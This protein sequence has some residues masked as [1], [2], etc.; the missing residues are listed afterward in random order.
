MT[1]NKSNFEKINKFILENKEK[2][3]KNPEII[4]ISKNHT[5]ESIN[6]AIKHGIR[7]FGEN[8]LQEA[9]IKFKPIKKKFKDIELHL[10]GPLQTKK[11]IKALE[12]FDVFHT[13][14]REKLANKIQANINNFSNKKFFIQVNIGKEEQKSGID[15]K[16]TPSFISYCQ[17]DLKLPI[18]GL[19]CI[20]PIDENAEDYFLKLKK[21][22]NENGLKYLSMGMSADY[23]TALLNGATHVRLGTTLFGS[24][25]KI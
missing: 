25:K 12:L 2:I 9:E 22:A 21:I 19:M 13:L 5:S 7:K 3:V 11:T 24:R 6:E 15:P 8:R 18:I 4:A 17:V 20:P 16:E 10:T 23:K 14:D 1:F